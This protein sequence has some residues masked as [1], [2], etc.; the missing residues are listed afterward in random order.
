[1][2]IE[3]LLPEQKVTLQVSVNGSI[4]SFDTKVQEV[5]IKKQF[6]LLDPIMQGDKGISFKGQGITVDLIVSY[7]DEK[8][9]I[10]Q[11]ISILLQKKQDGKLCYLV[12]C[13]QES[14]AFNRRENF[15]CYIGV[16][17][18]IQCG[19]SKNPH[20]VI[21]RDVSYTGFSVVCSPEVSLERG[22]VIHAHLRDRIEETSAN[23]SFNLY[24]LV[25]RMQVLPNGNVLYGCKLNGRV[26]G[27]D[28]YIMAKERYRLRKTS[29]L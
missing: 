23:Y 12:T 17:T 24:G 27:L 13:T 8:P 19:G 20:D 25:S 26:P 4:L 14:M 2:H 15:R 28:Q 18:F 10:F 16:P 3:E 7:S 6:I 29:G 1:M 5:S 11:D 21:I 22:H 9:H